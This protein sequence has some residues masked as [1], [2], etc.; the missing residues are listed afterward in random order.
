MSDFPN[1]EI[2]R[3]AIQIQLDRLKTQTERN[4]LGQFSTPIALAISILKYAKNIFPI[5]ENVRFLDPCIGTGSFYSALNMVFPSS[6]IKFA[7]GYEIDDHYGKPSRELWKNTILDYHLSDFIET[8][9]PTQESNR[10][11]LIIC[12]PPYVRHHHLSGKKDKLHDAAQKAAGMELSGLAGLYCYFIAQAHQWMQHN[13]IAGWLIP[14]EFM[15][16]NYGQ[17]VKEYLLNKVTLLHIHRFDPTEMQFNDALVTTAIVWFKNCNPEANHKVKFTYGG[18]L[19]CPNLEKMIAVQSLIDEKKWTRFPLLGERT[20]LDTPKLQDFFSIKRGLATGNNKY[21][22]L[23]QPEIQSNALPQC[24]FT[25]ILPSPRYLRKNIIDTTIDGNP[26]IDNKYYLLDCKLSISD[27]QEKYPTLYS[28]LQ[29]GVKL[30]IPDGYLCKSR[31]VWY[32]QEVRNASMFYCTYIGRPNQNGQKPFRFILNKSNALVTNAYLILYPKPFLREL[33]LKHDDLPNQIFQALNNI[34]ASAM[35]EE[36]RVYGG[37]LHK[38]EPKELSCLPATEI[39]QVLKR[40]HISDL[41]E[42]EL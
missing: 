17:A 36:G 22:I 15:D 23:T 35:I 42:N 39:V 3:Q 32:Q 24:V 28:Y 5:G 27:I 37:G 21:F 2:K 25:P 29:L 33:L 31:K 40:F 4:V 16:V 12:N 10:Y 9:V 26:C 14:S 8:E 30:G 11:N 13:G 18:S 7:K 38:L 34:T 41:N 6:Q 20:N 1:I 19:E